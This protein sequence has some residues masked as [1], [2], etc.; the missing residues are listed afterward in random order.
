MKPPFCTLNQRMP[1]LPN[2]G[3]CGSRA[4]GS[5]IG[6][7]LYSPVFTSS[8]P[9][10]PPQLPPYQMLPS[11]P[12]P[13]SRPHDPLAMPDG[14]LWWSGQFANRLGRLDPKT[15]EMKEYPIPIRGGPHGL[16]ND[17]V[18]T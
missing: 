2:N 1:S 16:I 7:N 11:L 13:G 3:V 10:W 5:G 18:H 9:I 6:K 12:T 15:G 8:L 17:T 4:F 14:T